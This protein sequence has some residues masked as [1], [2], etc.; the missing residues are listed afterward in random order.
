METRVLTIMMTDI[1]GFTERTASTSR[2]ELDRLLSVHEDLLLPIVKLF[3]GTLVK[4]IGDALLVT[5]ESPTN[6]VLCGLMMQERL[7]EYNAQTPDGDQLHVRVA[8]STGEVQVR[9]RD[10]F[11]EAVNIAARIEG[12]TE[13]GEIFFTEAV[14]LA[15][16]K[17][18]VPSSEVGHHRLKGIPEAIKVY[19]VIQDENSEQY[20]HLLEK[21]RGKNFEDIATPSGMEQSVLQQ[22]RFNMIRPWWSIAGVLAVTVVLSWILLRDPLVTEL[23]RID[24]ALTAGNVEQAMAIA[25][26][27]ANQEPG[28]E[29]VIAALRKVIA[30][31]VQAFLDK[32]SYNAATEHA[33]SRERKYAFLS[34][35][36]LRK[37]ILITK[38]AAYVARG[39]IRASL[40]VYE[41]L[42]ARHA[43]DDVWLEI[44]RQIGKGDYPQPLAI[45][46]ALNYIKD[47]PGDMEA[48]PGEILLKSLQHRGPFGDT[49]EQIRESLY[50]RY[51]K[52]IEVSRRHL[53]DEDYEYRLNS[54]FLL[55]EAGK[56]TADES[57]SYHFYNVM[58][59]GTTHR[60]AL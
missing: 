4:T 48:L 10:V 49:V 57:L 1:Q 6:A 46:S 40:D 27:L 26:L 36:D 52:S 15:M 51:P 47:K 43:G 25:D 22:R 45:V 14:Y 50:T 2:E 28:E 20:Q 56:L 37:H 31:E 53:T 17:S 59:L 30:A 23:E 54:Y 44:M 55:K 24:A 11:G 21:L 3:H 12:I 16:N 42:L 13:A 19:K 18:E 8:I 39:N 7:K 5:F 32:Q 29:R 33:N 35:D 34:L 41:V 38:A 60:T 9:D 58:H